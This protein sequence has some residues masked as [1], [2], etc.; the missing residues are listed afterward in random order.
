MW[1]RLEE[2]C[3]RLI[4]NHAP[5]LCSVRLCTWFVPICSHFSPLCGKS[6]QES[7]PHV[8][9]HFEFELHRVASVGLFSLHNRTSVQCPFCCNRSHTQRWC[10]GALTLRNICPCRGTNLNQKYMSI[11]KMRELHVLQ[12]SKATTFFLTTVHEEC[13][14]TERLNNEK[15]HREEEFYRT[16]MFVSPP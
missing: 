9:N 5:C 10:R 2:D 4:C 11:I 13:Y 8:W 3:C 7:L 14:V 15:K 6:G 1:F 16:I 12:A